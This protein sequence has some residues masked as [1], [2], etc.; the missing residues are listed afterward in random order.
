MRKVAQVKLGEHEQLGHQAVHLLG[1]GG[2]ARG[3]ALAHLGRGGNAVAQS[4]GVVADGGEWGAQV[5]R[6][7]RDELLSV[8]LIAPLALL[9]RLELGR[10]AVERV[11]N[12]AKLV[13]AIIADAIGEVT[14]RELLHTLF[15]VP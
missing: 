7:T 14:G 11:R 12:G 5:V 10:H 13:V 9:R 15:E 2:D 3:V 6:D 4:L 1:L 8:A